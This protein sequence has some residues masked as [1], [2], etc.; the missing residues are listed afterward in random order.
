MRLQGSQ[1]RENTRNGYSA[2]CSV[3]L[4]AVT[5]RTELVVGGVTKA[6]HYAIDSHD[7]MRISFGAG[8][9]GPGPN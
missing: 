6:Q 7:G 1:E 8:L 5:E 4:D 3:G 9:H 2:I